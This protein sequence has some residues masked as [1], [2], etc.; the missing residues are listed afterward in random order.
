MK[1]RKKVLGVKFWE[2]KTTEMTKLRLTEGITVTTALEDVQSQRKI[3]NMVAQRTIRQRSSGT[4]AKK[5]K[6]AEKRDTTRASKER[7]PNR[8]PAKHQYSA[9]NDYKKL[10]RKKVKVGSK[11]KQN[12]TA[13]SELVQRK[14][15]DEND[16]ALTSITKI[17]SP[18][19]AKMRRRRIERMRKRERN[20]TQKVSGKSTAPCRVMIPARTH[21]LTTTHTNI[22]IPAPAKENNEPSPPMVPSMKDVRNTQRSMARKE[23]ERLIDKKFKRNG[24]KMTLAQQYQQNKFK[25]SHAVRNQQQHHPLVLEDVAS[26]PPPPPL[27]RDGDN[28]SSKNNTKKRNPLQ[29]RRPRPPNTPPNPRAAK[30]KGKGKMDRILS[31]AAIAKSIIMSPFTKS[32]TARKRKRKSKATVQFNENI[33]TTIS[34]PET[35]GRLSIVE[36]R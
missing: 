11:K 26:P 4:T 33:A 3:A 34:I 14:P 29:P 8:L 17:L 35:P 6:H 7:D 23:I 28:C 16:Y 2:S 15:A 25:D 9:N 24:E 21:P 31:P 22:T 32:S 20:D 12:R 10:R 19:S 1:V 18:F 13:K 30:G 5:E 27:L 36:F